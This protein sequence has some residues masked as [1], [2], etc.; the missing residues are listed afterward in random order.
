MDNGEFKIDNEGREWGQP[1][2][3]MI[4]DDWLGNT[5]R[6]FE[7]IEEHENSLSMKVLTR[8]VYRKKPQVQGGLYLR[9]FCDFNSNTLK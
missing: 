7:K 1:C 5:I 4:L 3:P 8:H 2:L 6:L 9:L